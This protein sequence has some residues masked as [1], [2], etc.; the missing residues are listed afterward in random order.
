MSSPKLHLSS[1]WTIIGTLVILCLS[2]TPR[3]LIHIVPPNN[4][5]YD[6]NGKVQGYS[7]DM[8]KKK[9]VDY[10]NV[11]GLIMVLN[12]TDSGKIDK[13]IRENPDWEFIFYVGCKQKDTAKVK[14]VLS[15]F[16]CDFPVILDFDDEFAEKNFNQKYSAIG[17][18]CDSKD[19]SKAVSC[20]GTRQSFF[21]SDFARVKS[22]IK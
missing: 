17:F 10:F 9:V 6:R 18:I 12:Y 14:D 20:I 1:H 13:I 8:S 3:N 19:R 22:T 2:C 7:I 4:N 21:D 11:D 16:K 15:W 5:V